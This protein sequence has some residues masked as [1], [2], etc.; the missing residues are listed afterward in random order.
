[1]KRKLAKILWL[2]LPEVG[3]AM[4]NL[5]IILMIRWASHGRVPVG[6]ILDCLIW[7]EGTMAAFVVLGMLWDWSERNK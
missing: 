4:F 5:A 7:V 6:E 2:V 1:M 3:V